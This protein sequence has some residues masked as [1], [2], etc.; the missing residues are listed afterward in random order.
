ME[1]QVALFLFRYKHCVLPGLGELQLHQHPAIYSG[2]EE[3]IAAPVSYIQFHNDLV[4]ESAF[5]PFIAH[6]NNISVPSAAKHVQEFIDQIRSVSSDMSVEI[7]SAGKFMVNA[8]GDLEFISYDL[9]KEMFPL[10]EAKTIIRVPDHSILVG[11]KV[12]NATK[13]TAYYS[14]Q[15]IRKTQWWKIF[16][17]VFFSAAAVYLCYYFIY[18]Q[19]TGGNIEKVNIGKEPATYSVP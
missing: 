9:P 7:P 3:N 8:K 13:M 10:A 14:E 15:K 17:G 6:R 2:V 4:N 11:D 1:E 18:Q 19:H 5:I 12:S 16:A